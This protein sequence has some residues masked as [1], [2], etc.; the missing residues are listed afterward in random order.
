VGIKTTNANGVPGRGAREIT[1]RRFARCRMASV[2]HIL[3]I[4]VLVALD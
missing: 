4:V 1:N 2:D 3:V